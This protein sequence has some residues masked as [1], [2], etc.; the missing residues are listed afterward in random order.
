MGNWRVSADLLAASRFVIS[1]LAD[2]VG[3]LT[4]LDHPAGPWEAAF[5]AGNRV[6]YDDMLNAHPI[7][8]AIARRCWW[9]RI[10]TRLGWMAD[11]L[12][13]PPIADQ[14][15]FEQE[16]E[17]LGRDFD[18]D[19]VRAALLDGDPTPLPPEL[20]GAGV[21]EAL[22]ELLQWVWSSTVEADWPRR[23][24][25]LRGDIVARTSSG[26]CWTLVLCCGADLVVKCSIGGPHLATR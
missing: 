16:L 15:T 24:R 11:F 17:G 1:P 23:E 18:D 7:R 9:P 20:L 2:I 19:E 21:R 10:G 26:C 12:A 8:R 25:V 22:L 14:A 6:A 4:M 13:V 3:A 5:R